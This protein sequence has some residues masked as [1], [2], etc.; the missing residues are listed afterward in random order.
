MSETIVINGI[1]VLGTHNVDAVL[2]YK[3]GGTPVNNQYWQGRKRTNFINLSSTF[4]LKTVTF[5]LVYSGEN[6]REALLKK[7]KVEASMFGVS[8]IQMPDGFY[9]RCLL[10]S[11]SDAEIKGQQNNEIIIEVTYSLSGIQHDPLVTVN[12]GAFQCEATMPQMDCSLSVTVGAD[13]DTY[14]LGGVTFNDVEAGDVLEVDGINKRILKNGAPTIIEGFFEFPFVVS[15][16]NNFT[17][18]DNITVKY[19]PCYM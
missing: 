8:E 16:A 2:S 12:G 14:Q 10:D 18:E 6:R 5:T 3:I 11:I 9:Y 1:D 17:A 7:S 19:Y 15:G 13:A 4:G